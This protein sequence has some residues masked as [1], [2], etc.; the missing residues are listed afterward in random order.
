MENN[1]PIH[2]IK[3]G[4]VIASIWDNSKDDKPFY[5]TTVARLYI[6]DDGTWKRTSSFGISDLPLVAKAAD[7]AHTHICTELLKSQDS[8]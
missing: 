8:D 6:T 3:F 2:E 5:S 1:K 4:A 7:M